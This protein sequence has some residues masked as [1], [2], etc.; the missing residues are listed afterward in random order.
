MKVDITVEGDGTR[1]LAAWLDQDPETRRHGGIRSD[2]R[3]LA[4]QLGVLEVVQAT[5]DNLS[6]LAG[7][8]VAIDAWRST[9]SEPSRV[10][11]VLVEA[12][13]EERGAAQ[14]MIDRSTDDDGGPAQDMIDRPTD[15]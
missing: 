5:I 4:G 3:P 8:I 10:V 1:S 14:E 2:D 11:I 12:D 6:G 9:R 7:L 15:E 13:D